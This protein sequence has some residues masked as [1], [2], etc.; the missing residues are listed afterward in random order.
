MVADTVADKDDDAEELEST[1]VLG[2]GGGEWWSL[3]VV[4]LVA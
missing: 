3:D 2:V 4:S 1:H